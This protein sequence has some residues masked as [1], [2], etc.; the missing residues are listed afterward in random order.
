[1]SPRHELR[2]QSNHVSV[3]IAFWLAV[4]VCCICWRSLTMPKT[5]PVLAHF[6]PVAKSSVRAMAPP[7]HGLPA[8]MPRHDDSRPAGVQPAFQGRPQSSPF[9]PVE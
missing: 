5:T 6:Q 1:M 8:A 7:T 2:L 3:P 4:K 9:G